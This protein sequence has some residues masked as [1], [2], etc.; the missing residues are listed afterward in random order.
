MALVVAPSFFCFFLPGT[1]TCQKE[2]PVDIH[3]LA[4]IL[5]SLPDP[6]LVAD[7]EHRVCYMNRA[8][9]AHY[10]QGTDLLQSS[11]FDCHNETSQQSMIDVLAA[12]QAGEEERL[13]SANEK[14]RI[15]MRAV[16]D[17]QGNLLG[18]YER[19]APPVAIE[20]LA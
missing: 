16:R 20:S 6:I 8:A 7:T 19:Y 18:Y 17:A 4:A 5:D 13:I 2:F 14:R 1:Y 12:L 10:D 15:Y 9:V 11:L 3:L